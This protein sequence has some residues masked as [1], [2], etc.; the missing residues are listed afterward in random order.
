MAKQ[1]SL[2]L[3]DEMIERN[4]ESVTSGIQS[5]PCFKRRQVASQWRRE[6]TPY[7]QRPHLNYLMVGSFWGH[8]VGS[9]WTHKMTHTVSL[10]WATHTVSLLW[11]IHEIILMSSP[12][13][14]AV[15]SNLHCANR[16]QES[17]LY[18]F[19]KLKSLPWCTYKSI[20]WVTC[21]RQNFVYVL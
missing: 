4:V 3:I 20:C 5:I 2:D 16:H 9:L 17:W 7:S 18:L 21:R 14:V 10:L 13:G 19:I 6:L 12:C 1:W 11:A 15:S 8:S